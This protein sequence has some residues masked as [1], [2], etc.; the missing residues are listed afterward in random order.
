M[1]RYLTKHWKKWILIRF[2]DGLR[3]QEYKR[4]LD[5]LDEHQRRLKKSCQKKTR[6]RRPVVL[7][8]IRS[9]VKKELKEKYYC[10]IVEDISDVDIKQSI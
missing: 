7:T 2:I 6:Q 3:A 10:P 1:S 4:V 9:Y 8:R 5:Q